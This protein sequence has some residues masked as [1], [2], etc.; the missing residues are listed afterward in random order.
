MSPALQKLFESYPPQLMLAELNKMFEKT[1][2]VEIYDLV[3]ALHSYKQALGKSVSAHVL[4][5]KDLSP[6]PRSWTLE[7]E[8]PSLPRRVAKNKDK[9]EHDAAAS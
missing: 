9:A 3:D 7:E 8:L 2:A 1:Q 5:M 6:L 4:E